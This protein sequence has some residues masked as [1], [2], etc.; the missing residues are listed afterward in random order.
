M[1]SYF[2]L[3][4]GFIGVVAAD[5]VAWFNVSPQIL[6]AHRAKDDSILASQSIFES[7]PASFASSSYDYIIVGAGTAGLALAARLS[8][9]GQ[10]TVGVLEA[11]MSGL[12]IPIID[13]PGDFGA[14]IRTV[15]DCK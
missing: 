11:G 5:S 10:H 7:D 12:G 4:F 9:N 15:Y 3:A 13:I 8:E 14:G 2:A 1:K 6:F